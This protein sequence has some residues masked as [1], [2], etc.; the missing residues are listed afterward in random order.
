M[1]AI[2]AGHDVLSVPP[3]S[4]V[5]TTDALAASALR[6]PGRWS[7]WGGRTKAWV[8][9]A[10][11]SSP[12]HRRRHEWVRRC[13][14]APG[15]EFL[16]YTLEHGLVLT[17][18]H[19]RPPQYDMRNHRSCEDERLCASAAQ[20]L[21]TECDTG[22]I[23][24]IKPSQ[25]QQQHCLWWHAL[26]LEPKG[27]EGDCRIIHDFSAPAGT[28]LN[29]HI[30]YVRTS[31]DRVDAA[32][33]A[34]RRGCWLAK[35]DI[36][37]FFRHIGLDPFDW[38]L[39]GFRWDGEQ[40]IDTRL[41]FGQRNAPEVAYKFAMAIMWHVR[42]L[43]AAAGL[44]SWLEVSVVCDDWLVIAGTE[45]DCRCVWLLIIEALEALGFT[46]NKKPHKC[47]APCHALVWLGL[48]FDSLAM[49]VSLPAD[50]LA[51]AMRQVQ[52]VHDSTK[53]TRKQLDS[54]FG[55]LSW[56]SAV[57]Y[58]LR[59]M[60]HSIRHLRYR[61]DGG[62]R[63]AGHRLHVNATL[64]ADMRACLRILAQ[65][66]GDPTMAIIAQDAT[67]PTIHLD[68]RGGSGGVGVFIDGAFVGLTGPQVNALY[69]QLSPGVPRTIGLG[70]AVGPSV[71]ANHW[72]MMAFIVLLDMFPSFV[73]DRRIVVHSD[74]ISA[75]K[76]VR[77]LSAALDSP[78]M[79][80]LTREFLWRTVDLNVRVLPVHI[81]G[82]QNELADPLS[83]A[84]LPRF[85]RNM[86]RRLGEGGK[87]SVFLTMLASS[88]N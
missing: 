4:G 45:E 60:L 27:D 30:D 52:L 7:S 14:G 33:R 13:G 57:V 73:R 58:G 21:Q 11:A 25:W 44:Q 68:A 2:W 87:E 80:H 12:L 5:A 15:F 53:V 77:T 49:T 42:R 62:V 78:E 35:I 54:A 9:A 86:L 17:A 84:H 59:A 71:E 26:G 43:I 74:S 6:A 70:Q 81:P 47:V 83:R 50:K 24:R 36:S 8:R 46:V 32:F 66:N 72:E 85:A 75:I 1:G 88:E 63:G 61:S 55:F 34:M 37:A 67:P 18:T 38:P 41:N 79:A 29:D 20:I 64:R 65:L 82:V 28:S 56:A 10:A 3:Q 19:Q 40:F 76:C 51:K 16:A 69:P 23:L 48:M 31:Y 39:T 22:M